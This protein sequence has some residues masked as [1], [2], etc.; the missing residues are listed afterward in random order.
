LTT[1]TTVFAGLTAASDGLLLQALVGPAVTGTLRT[2]WARVPAPHLR[3][4]PS[5]PE[6]AQRSNCY[7]YCRWG[8]RHG[9]PDAGT[10]SPIRSAGAY[11]S[12][13]DVMIDA[14]AIALAILALG[15][16]ALIIATMLGSR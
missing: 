14:L 3:A 12:L 9:E 10:L 7:I 8:G 15:I 4:R 16:P 11:R 5:S 2:V 1:T 6:V 13:G